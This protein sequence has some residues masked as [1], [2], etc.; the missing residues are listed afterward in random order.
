MH[1]L[2]NQLKDYTLSPQGWSAK[3]I[4]VHRDGVFRSAFDI[5]RQ[6][7][8]TLRSLILMF[9]DIEKIDPSLIG[10]IEIEGTYA[11]HIQRQQADLKLF[12]EDESMLLSPDIDYPS[13]AGISNELKGKL[14]K[15]KPSSIGAAKRIEG[16]TPASLVN[17]LRYVKLNMKGEGQVD[18]Q[19]QRLG[20]V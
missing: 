1:R 5:L 6:P 15:V 8:I 3:G 14:E 18:A 9:P 17:L 13:I 12:L 2:M 4:E 11:S 7:D 20:A 16:M 19:T 10:R